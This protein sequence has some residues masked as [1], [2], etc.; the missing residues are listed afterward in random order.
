[1]NAEMRALLRNDILM[2][3]DRLGDYEPVLDALHLNLRAMGHQ[4]S[5]DEVKT[6]LRYL[7]DKGFV[8]TREKEISPELTRYRITAAGRDYLAKEGLA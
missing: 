1:M 6:E 8:T 4:S 2:G 3:L 5:R 7:M